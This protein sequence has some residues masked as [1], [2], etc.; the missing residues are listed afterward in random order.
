MRGVFIV[1]CALTFM[2]GLQLFVL[3]ERT[4]DWFAWTIASPMTAAFL[5][6]FYWMVAVGSGV[7][8]RESTWAGAR[9]AVPGVLVFVWL[10]G[11]ASLL[12]LDALHLVE[13]PT[14]ARLAAWAWLVVYMLAP[15]IQTAIYVV[16]LR[17]PGSDPPHQAPLPVWFRAA[18]IAMGVGELLLGVVVFLAPDVG[19]DLWPW[20]LTDFTA[21]AVGAWVVG[22]AVVVLTL[23]RINER[24]AARIPGLSTLALVI[25]LLIGALRYGDEIDGGHPATAVYFGVLVVLLAGAL[26]SLTVLNRPTLSTGDS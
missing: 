21:R 1:G 18:A 25:L 12:H 20:A 23:A 6:A 16:Q 17:S 13:G 14:T 9:V 22:Y 10:R 19:A 4:D 3:S 7:A 15:P 11:I 2:A 8:S 26:Y 24:Y 5:G